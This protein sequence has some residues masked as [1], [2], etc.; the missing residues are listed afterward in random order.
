[1]SSGG[2]RLDTEKN[3]MKCYTLSENEIKP[4]I[5]LEGLPV[6]G[7]FGNET[8]ADGIRIVI[9]LK[10]RDGIVPDELLDADAG[11][12]SACG[13]I[14]LTKAGKDSR[15]RFAVLYDPREWFLDSSSGEDGFIVHRSRTGFI[16]VSR[17]KAFTM[18][19]ADGSLKLGV[20]KGSA[21]VITKTGSIPMKIPQPGEGWFLATME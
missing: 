12:A 10:E 7:S 4:G 3:N 16:A 18:K 20:G 2:C 15:G 6:D 17:G 14:V 8:T 13:R 1:M 21:P 9:L 19:S 11:R 5:S